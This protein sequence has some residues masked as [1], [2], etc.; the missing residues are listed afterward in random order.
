[1]RP[2][3]A[4]PGCIYKYHDYCNSTNKEL[5]CSCG[6]NRTVRIPRSRLETEKI[7]YVDLF[8]KRAMKW[9]GGSSKESPWGSLRVVISLPAKFTTN[10]WPL[11]IKRYNQS[12]LAAH[13]GLSQ[14]HRRRYCAESARTLQSEAGSRPYQNQYQARQRCP[15]A[16][17]SP[18]NLPRFL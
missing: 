2:A 14:K 18:L 15:A 12:D 6:L 17:R 16:P 1:M 3:D 5:P 8:W 9:H 4:T 10:R 13:G 11:S 7:M